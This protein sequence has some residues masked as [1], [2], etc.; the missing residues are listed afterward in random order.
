LAGLAL[1]AASPARAETITFDTSQSPFTP[2]QDNQG[3]YQLTEAR[4]I[5]SNYFVGQ[6]RGGLGTAYWRNF[7]TF[8][9]T[10]LAPNMRVV[11][12]SLQLWTYESLGLYNATYRLWDVSTDAAT[13]NRTT[14]ISPAIFDDLGSGTNYGQF[15]LSR[16]DLDNP[17][18]LSLN[19]AALADIQAAAGGFFSIGGSLSAAAGWDIFTLF[20]GSGADGVQ[21]L[22]LDV[23]PIPEPS[24]LA[25]CG[26]AIPL[27]LVLR[28]RLAA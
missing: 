19:A 21:R 22:I 6:V 16:P 17:L 24:S 8:D 5:N 28:R 11:S 7:F 2:G 1:L 23:E 12:A 4:V 25:L 14:A 9:L 15:A 18:S 13:L 26:L 3:Y 10:A 20:N 27:C